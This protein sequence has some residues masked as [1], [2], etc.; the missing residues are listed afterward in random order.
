MNRLIGK[1]CVVTGA[2]RGIGRAV[3]RAFA[4]EG[5]TVIGADRIASELEQEMAELQDSGL[6]AIAMPL[7]LR[8]PESVT[9]FA[10]EVLERHPRVDVLANVAGIIKEKHLE[11]T[12]F[13]D[14]NAILE[15]N[16][17]GPFLMC[18]AFASSM[19]HSGGSIIN[20]SSRA[21]VLGFANEI[22][23]CASKFG[24]EG[25]SR[26]IAQ[27]LGASGIAVNT[28]TPGTP[29]QTSMS[30]QTYSPEM[31]KIWKDPFLITPAFVHLAMQTSSG[32]H[33]QYV[34]AWE[35]SERLR[36][37]GWDL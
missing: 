1:T 31:R 6:N 11:E 2:A 37:E 23:Y 26:A 20:V 30:E 24:L 25:L 17:R 35:T 12:S 13:E 22:A 33:D 5:A 36:A 28:I 29:T 15:V 16:L 32:I 34:N 8:M 14:W 18:Q 7:E 3:A 21:G 19:K 4:L 27:D 9:A 10:E